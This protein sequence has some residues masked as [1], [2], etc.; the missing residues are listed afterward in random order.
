MKIAYLALIFSFITSSSYGGSIIGSSNCIM[1]GENAESSIIT[2]KTIGKNCYASCQDYCADKFKISLGSFMSSDMKNDDDQRDVSAIKNDV[3][4][5]N[6]DRVEKC[7]TDCYNGRSTTTKVRIPTKFSSSGSA[8]NDSGDSPDPWSSDSSSA[9]ERFALCS[10]LSNAHFTT[11]GT[12]AQG[13]KF[14]ITLAGANPDYKREENDNELF[15]V[16]NKVYLCG[17]KT[18]IASPV[19]FKEKADPLK[20]AFQPSYA[21]DVISYNGIFI[22]TCPGTTETKFNPKYF[23]SSTSPLMTGI[24]VKNGD[25]L[26]IKY[27]GRYYSSCNEAG[28]N[29]NDSNRQPSIYIGDEKLNFDLLNVENQ[30]DLAKIPEECEVCKDNPQDSVCSS[31]KCANELPTA[32]AREDYMKD[33]SKY[34]GLIPIVTWAN[35]PHLF[36]IPIGNTSY[37]SDKKFRVTLISGEVQGISSTPR[38]LKISYPNSTQG[39]F[40]LGGYF[41]S[42]AW[43]GCKYADGERLEYTLMNE[44]VEESPN[45]NEYLSRYANWQNLDFSQGKA[46]VTVNSSDLALP[47]VLDINTNDD[48]EEA[49]RGKKKAKIYFRI[50]TLSDSEASAI[51]ASSYSRADTMGQYNLKVLPEPD[52]IEGGLNGFVERF[53]KLLRGI[54]KIIFDA[55]TTNRTF[56]NIIRALLVFYIAFTGLSF[57]I[58]IAQIS[59]SEGVSRILKLSIVIMLLSNTSFEFFN[60]FLFQAFSFDEMSKLAN[61]F[62]PDLDVN[63]AGVTSRVQDCFNN[64]SVKVT[65]LCVIQKDLN[66]FFSTAFWNRIIGLI[67]SGFFIPAI[68]ITIGIILYTIVIIKITFLFCVALL[69]MT[70][71]L[72]LAPIFIPLIL[73]KYTKTMFDFWTKQLVSLMFQPLF[74]FTAISLFR[75]IFLILV[76]L[77]LGVSACK[78]CWLEFISPFWKFCLIGDF[79]VPIALSSA[80]G[81]ASLPMNNIGILIAIFFVGYGMYT[82]CNFASSMASRLMSWH[83]F[84]I[85]SANVGP[86]DLYGGAKNAFSVLKS[87]LKAPGMIGS[88]LAIDDKSRKIREDRRTKK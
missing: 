58:G 83:S 45:F 75:G 76:Q 30:N 26:E 57:M 13:K 3:I 16:N 81:V 41:V 35:S 49:N 62:T 38:E 67:M 12:V 69:A 84:N 9:G 59:Q 20:M 15:N 42:I 36:T 21:N 82:F 66:M 22:K 2:V 71:T 33:T 24:K 68:A 4:T 65:F 47:N 56:I 52:D 29:L 18:L 74:I 37:Y 63:I 77:V 19:F 32:K 8:V 51:G 55:F 28:C 64:S 31:D 88:L 25:Y 34:R 61:L 53:E 80:P 27:M 14:H 78:V 79:Y 73:F 44:A 70:V 54:T 39:G 87:P 40:P 7:L 72:A 6:R 50:K 17:F 86:Q 5:A 1:S 23:N 10:T 43:R 60:K 11:Q 85:T 48:V 46:S